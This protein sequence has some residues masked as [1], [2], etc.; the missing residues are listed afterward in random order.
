MRHDIS[1]REMERV[2]REVYA[3]FK[4]ALQNC[5]IT[6][7][8]NYEDATITVHLRTMRPTGEI[9]HRAHRFSIIE[10]NLADVDFVAYH[11]ERIALELGRAI[12]L[13]GAT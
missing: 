13:S 8:L 5:E 6:T 12:F 4:A 1:R 10:Y 11:A 7:G 3:N 2:E 9:L